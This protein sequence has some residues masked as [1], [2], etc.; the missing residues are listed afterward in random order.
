MTTEPGEWE[1]TVLLADF[2]Q[3][4][5]GKLYVLGGGWSLCG[6]GPFTHALAVKVG[7]PWTETNQ[8]HQLEAVL[9]DEDLHPVALGEPPEEIRFVTEFEVGRPPGLPAGSLIDVPMAVN[10]GP[11]QLAPGRGYLWSVRIDGEEMERAGFR[12]RAVAPG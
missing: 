3:V 7:V 9:V 6:P 5:D 12:V 1:V 2:A 10:L 11:L 8:G 4:A